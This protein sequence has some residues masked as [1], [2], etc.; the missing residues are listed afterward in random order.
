MSLTARTTNADVG[1]GPPAGRSDL[2]AFESPRR[3]L[4]GCGVARLIDLPAPW[5]E[6]LDDVMDI[7]ARHRGERAPRVESNEPEPGR[8]PV[9]FGALP[10]DRSR[11]ARFVIPSVL[12]GR[13]TEGRRWTT[14]VSDGSSTGRTSRRA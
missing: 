8:G 11:P 6:H 14:V 4:W 2:V 9:A 5:T 12:H 3:Q 1:P 7:L 10:F 13:A